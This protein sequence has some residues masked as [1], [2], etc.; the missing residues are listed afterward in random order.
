VTRLHSTSQCHTPPPK[1]ITHF[2]PVRLLVRSISSQ[3]IIHTGLTAAWAQSS[4][5]PQ[6]WRF[7][8]NSLSLPHAPSLSVCLFLSGFYESVSCVYAFFSTCLST[9]VVCAACFC[10]RFYIH[11]HLFFSF[12]LFLII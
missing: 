1:I 3:S 8:N 6:P 7:T 12:L 10:V 5:N 9:C 2:I 11:N 4:V